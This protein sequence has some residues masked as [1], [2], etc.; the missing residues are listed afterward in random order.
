MS[1]T[2][3][4]SAPLPDAPYRGIEPFRFIDQQL[5]AA[6]GEETWELLSKVT[7]YR[8]VLLYGESGTGKSS[9]IN[10]GVLPQA[11]K[12]GY[13]PDRLRIQPFAG[14]EIK[15]E[16]ILQTDGADPTYLES[17]FMGSDEPDDYAVTEPESFELSLTAFLAQ[18][19]L[20]FPLKTRNDDLKWGPDGTIHENA[21]L[22]PLLIFDQ[23]EEFV[24]LF[25]EAHRAKSDSDQDSQKQVAIVQNEVLHTLINLIRDDTIP[26]KIVFVFREDYFTKLSLLFDYCPELIDQALRLLPP[27][28]GT[29]P[30]IIR[31]PF[32]NPHLR[33]HF[34]GPAE[35]SGSELSERMAQRISA[36]LS[37]RSE[38]HFVNL[39][40]LQIV[41]LLLWRSREP[42]ALYQKL[43]I[44]GLL[45]HYGADVFS[46]F[47]PEVQ[48]K[49]IALLATMLTASNT[50]NIVSEADLKVTAKREKLIRQYYDVIDT[51]CRHQ[52]VRRER[53]RELYFYELSSEYLIPWINKLAAD[54][55]LQRLKRSAEEERLRAEDERHRALRFKRLLFASGVLL[56]VL[57]FVGFLAASL[58][59]RSIRTNRQ[60]VKTEQ[61][62]LAVEQQKH[63]ADTK[64]RIA[65][66][67]KRK[68]LTAIIVITGTNDTEKL[69]AIAQI[70]KWSEE[71]AFPPELL[72]LL[73]AAQSRTENQEIKR[74]ASQV[75]AQ[76]AQAD[77]NLSESIGLATEANAS[78]AEKLPPLFNMYLA[79]KSQHG[80]ALK[81]SAVLKSH[82]YVVASVSTGEGDP[83]EWDNELRYFR[84]PEKGQPEPPEIRRMLINATGLNWK[85]AYNRQYA[86]S[87]RGRAG[88]LELWFARP[89]GQLVLGFADEDGKS[90][91]DASFKVKFVPTGAGV[92]FTSRALHV[93]VPQGDYDVTI[94]IKGYADLH[95]FVSIK[96]G[97]TVE[98]AELKLTKD[99]PSTN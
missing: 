24:T 79:D 16:R 88:Q 46:H 65:E 6:R 3:P 22:R 62:R 48:E 32:V 56:V 23:F 83:P 31:A 55:E 53:H 27:R 51:L 26:L 18:L 33:E 73:V 68:Y 80:L 60:L 17:N 9:L 78:L 15:V 84:S 13:V 25:E 20:G 38:G 63:A 66:Q 52:I 94:S 4:S 71:N 11:L 67:E 91:R 64:L 2:V 61:Q 47:E 93:T 95:K 19:K 8:G 40:E 41:C 59:L 12:E 77:V 96:G 5:F 89:S 58:Y 97:D 50:R 37:K 10:A 98:W 57:L 92:S 85:I 70:K 43:G 35:K 69:E 86:N 30:S 7:L 45:E 72:L 76:A 81:V 87:P 29:L 34:L 44:P 28:L 75:L 36:D 82:G 49:A 99:K 1:A 39:S 54:L 42:E 90:L 14:R 21:P 74:A